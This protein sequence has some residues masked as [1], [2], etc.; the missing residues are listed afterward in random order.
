MTM[1]LDLTLDEAAHQLGGDYVQSIADYDAVHL[2]ILEMSDYL[3][4]GIIDQFPNQFR[5]PLK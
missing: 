3:S 5:G 2:A 1:H 4:Q